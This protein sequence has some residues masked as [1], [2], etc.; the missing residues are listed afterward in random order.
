MKINFLTLF[1][2]YYS[3]F[4]NESI[5]GKAIE[6]KLIEVNI[7]DWRHFATG[8]QKKV[9]DTVYGGGKG[10]LLKVEPIKLALD[11]VKGIKILVS[12]QGKVFNQEMAQKLASENNEI[13]FIAGRYE[14]FDERILNYV[15]EE[16]SLGDFI[17]TGGELPS[18]IMADSIIRLVDG[19]I[20]K[21]SHELESFNNNLLDFAQYTKPRN[22]EG[23]EVPEVLV[24]GNHA[25]IEKWR[26]ESQIRKTKL[27]RPDLFERYKNEK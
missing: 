13:T 8:K 5:I 17:V 19:V 20:K 6:N 21:E 23:Y 18:M 14:G 11:T 25:E 22:F 9:D 16:I 4:T 7:V 2:E 24:N 10:M 12:P 3:S 27:N 15:D 26:K 1:P